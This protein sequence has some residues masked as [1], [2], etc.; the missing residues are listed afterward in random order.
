MKDSHEA[1]SLILDSI[2]E[3]IV[4]VD[5]AGKIQYANKSWSNFSVNNACDMG[6]DWLGV[7]Y[8]DE[9]DKASKV[10]DDFGSQAAVGIR[11]VINKEQAK[12]YFEYPCHSPDEKRWF[13]MRVTAVQINH[14]DHFV[15][16]HQNITERKLAE[17][18]VREQAC[19]DGLTD[20]ANRRTFNQFLQ[21]EWR[22]CARV[23]QPISL[24]IMDLDH[25]KLLNDT[26]GHQ[27]GDECLVKIG[28]LLKEFNQRPG[29]ICA[30]YG[31][32]E[33]ALVWGN[34]SLVNAKQLCHKLIEAINTLNIA[35]QNSP[36][37]DHLTASIGLATMIPKQEQAES[38][39]LTNADVMLYKAKANG[40]NRVQ[41]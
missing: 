36:V 29:D 22:R 1:L 3:H 7:N 16:S 5:V 41:S 6:S 4:V 32:E 13:M 33:F 2:T 8:L 39:L 20:I 18:A 10:G 27:A 31:G 12:F 24:A 38:A 19:I 37:S 11:S 40:R 14:A 15:I 21:Q 9:C 34:T 35:N 17:E 25:F 30:R 23:Q 26:Y 28:A